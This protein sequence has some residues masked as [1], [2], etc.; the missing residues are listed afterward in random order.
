VVQW[1]RWLG[2]GEIPSFNLSGPNESIKSGPNLIVKSTWTPSASW[3]PN[4]LLAQSG[5]R[6]GRLIER[7]TLRRPRKSSAKGCMGTIT[8]DF[9]Y[10]IHFPVV[11]Y[12][13][14]GIFIGKSF[15]FFRKM[16]YSHSQVQPVRVALDVLHLSHGK[17]V[18]GEPR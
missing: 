18:V 15:V 9:S 6:A 5:E 3:Q 13:K 1:T 8:C 7:T 2:R 12:P 14:N 16:L 10:P 17:G 4:T 11:A